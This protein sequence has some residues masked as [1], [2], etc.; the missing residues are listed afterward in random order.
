MKLTWYNHSP[1]IC[2]SQTHF[3]NNSVDILLMKC[4]LFSVNKT[5][6]GHKRRYALMT[7][8]AWSV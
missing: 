1:D 2:K 6:S 7:A 8:E 5:Q 3:L 4:V